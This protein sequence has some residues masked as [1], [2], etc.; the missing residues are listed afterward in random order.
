M[1]KREVRSDNWYFGDEGTSMMDNGG[2]DCD[3]MTMIMLDGDVDD[4]DNDDDDDG[5]GTDNDKCGDCV[6]G[7]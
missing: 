4:I 3:V 1:K 6:V 7:K 5:D 2:I